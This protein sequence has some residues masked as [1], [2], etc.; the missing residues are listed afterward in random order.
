MNLFIYV[1]LIQSIFNVTVTTFFAK[2]NIV[3]LFHRNYRKNRCPSFI[4]IH[5]EICGF[6]QPCLLSQIV[7]SRHR[8]KSTF[9]TEEELTFAFPLCLKKNLIVLF[10]VLLV[11]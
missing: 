9:C 10:H 7:G 8:T 5:G 6:I 11:I 2:S 4:M 1:I 3:L